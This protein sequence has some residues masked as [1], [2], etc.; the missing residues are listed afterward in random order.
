VLMGHGDGER[1]LRLVDLRGLSA[2]LKG[3]RAV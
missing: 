3:S 1:V 2:G